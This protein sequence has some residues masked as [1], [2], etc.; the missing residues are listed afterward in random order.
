[1]K[2]SSDMLKEW[3]EEHYNEIVN[4]VLYKRDP[5]QETFKNLNSARNLIN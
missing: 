4:K 5:M 2:N 3:R 1:M